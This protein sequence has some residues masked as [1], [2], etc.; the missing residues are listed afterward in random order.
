MPPPPWEAP[1]PGYS[2]VGG[3]ERGVWKGG[4][5][6]K[7]LPLYR[8]TPPLR[9]TPPYC[10]R[11]YGFHGQGATGG[12]EGDT[13]GGVPVSSYKGPPS[14]L[15]PMGSSPG[16]HRVL[17][18]AHGYAGWGLIGELLECNHKTLGPY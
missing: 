5:S 13:L 3:G 4:H 9:G 11:E 6:W 2:L 17:A 14:P 18:G 7:R 12:R 8:S 10:S 15:P 16:V 1:F